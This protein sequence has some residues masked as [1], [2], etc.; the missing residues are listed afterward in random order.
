[1]RRDDQPTADYERRMLLQAPTRH[2][3][4]VTGTV[5]LAGGS[6][7]VQPV[8]AVTKNS[9]TRTTVTAVTRNVTPVTIDEPAKC[10]SEPLPEATSPTAMPHSMNLPVPAGKGQRYPR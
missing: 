1:M 7:V 4:R 3:L 2:S 5:R 9:P 10:E 6:A 8:Y